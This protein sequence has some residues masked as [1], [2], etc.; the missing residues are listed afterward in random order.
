ML[1]LVVKRG[2]KIGKRKGISDFGLQ[3]AP[4][5]PKAVG[6]RLPRQRRWDCGFRISDFGLRIAPPEAVGFRISDCGLRIADLG[7]TNFSFDIR[8]EIYSMIRILLN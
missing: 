1:N 6:F 3:I 7:L 5:P 2:A 8:Y 4:A